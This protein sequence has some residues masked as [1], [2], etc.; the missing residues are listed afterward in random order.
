MKLPPNAVAALL[1]R[2]APWPAHLAAYAV[3][4]QELFRQSRRPNNSMDNLFVVRAARLLLDGASPYESERFVYPPSSIPV[5]LLQAHVP[6]AT[7]RAASAFVVGALLLVAW[8]AALRLFDAG[9]GSWLGALGVAAASSFIPAMHLAVL[10]SWTVLVA[11]L[12]SVALLLMGRGRWLAG[13]VVIGLSIAVKPMLM[14][15]GLVF[16]LARRWGGFAAAAGLPV[17]LC[18]A[19]LPFIPQP[20]LFFTKTIPFLLGG[21]DEFA[22]PFD[23]S[24]QAILPRLGVE[25][26]PVTVA[27]VAVFVLMIVVAVL[28]WRRG[29]DERVRIVE[30]SAVLMLGTFLVSTPSFD[31]Y[32]MILVPAL[33]AA[34]VVPGSAARS[35]W[36]WIALA[37]FVTSLR[38][39]F[40]DFLDSGRSG[41]RQVFKMFA[42]NVLLLAMFTVTAWTRRRRGAPADDGAGPGPA[43]AVPAPRRGEAPGERPAAPTTGQGAQAALS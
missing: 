14:P 36:F 37:P 6:D 20:G 40:I 3:V 13:G 31:H 29:D 43:A 8:W 24:L 9:L 11:C 33:V 19:V 26:A 15:V 39:V 38:W 28:R 35:V 18:A 1:L 34:V 17:V 32:P 4:L 41:V 42:W 25:G 5:A 10:G 27:R 12:A 16:L 23:G 22:R 30:T 2:P 7:I 21:Q